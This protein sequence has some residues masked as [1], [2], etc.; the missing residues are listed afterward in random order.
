[1]LALFVAMRLEG[2]AIERHLRGQRV[3]V[4]GLSLVRGQALGGE[5]ALCITGVGADRA[6]QA[7]KQAIAYLSPSAAVCLG[8][9]GGAVDGPRVGDLVLGQR[10]AL[11]GGRAWVESDPGLIELA[12]RAAAGAALRAHEGVVVTVP[13]FLPSE[14]EKRSVGAET[15]A[16]AI[17]MEAYH[18]GAAAA[19]AGVPFLSV[20]VVSDGVRHTLRLPTDI[21][22]PGQSVRVRRL[23]AAIARRPLAVPGGLLWAVNLGRAGAALSRFARAFLR[24]WAGRMP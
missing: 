23:A 1:M 18:V 15:G 20:R 4:E 9:A 19:E 2:R 7:A 8:F 22:G 17:D 14:E 5:V 16:L 12:R 10:T 6:R 3:D 24:T 11:Y 13:R 21:L